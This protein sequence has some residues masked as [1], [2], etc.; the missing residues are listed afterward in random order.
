MYHL[1]DVYKSFTRRLWNDFSLFQLNALIPVNISIFLRF[2]NRYYEI[3]SFL[4]YFPPKNQPSRGPIGSDPS[5][6]RNKSHADS[7]MIDRLPC[8]LVDELDQ[9][10]LGIHSL[11]V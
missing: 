6:P 9:T 2:F 11:D 5:R 8:S 1:H 7:A 10:K 3:D 4:N